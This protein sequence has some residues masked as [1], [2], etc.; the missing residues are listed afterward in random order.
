MELIPKKE[1]VMDWKW[2][3]INHELF[4]VNKTRVH[5]YNGMLHIA[6]AV[7]RILIKTFKKSNY[8]DIIE[9]VSANGISRNMLLGTSLTH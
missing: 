5:R 8:F 1:F 3:V 6:P 7:I 9:R 4:S 2:L